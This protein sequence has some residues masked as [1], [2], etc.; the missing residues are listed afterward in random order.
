MIPV[1]DTTDLILRG[2]H[3]DDFDAFAR[4]GAS[5]RA[6][7]VGGPHDR[8]DSWRAFL[9]GIGHWAL[10]GFGMWI[11]EHRATGDV[12]GRVGMILND[13]WDEPELGWHIYDGF[14]GQN[15]AFQAVRAARHYGASH[16][17]LDRV[18][19]YIDRQN[20]RSI[21]LAHRLGANFERETTLLGKPCQIFRHPSDKAA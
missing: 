10:R 16:Q 20:I 18:I 7:F 8:W 9:A 4:F 21:R 17:G 5:S 11:I 1:V 2:Y 19:S 14:E 15:L 3:E 6:A 12:V 13:G